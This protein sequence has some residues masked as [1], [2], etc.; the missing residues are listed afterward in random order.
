MNESNKTTCVDFDEIV[1][2]IHE[3][4]DYDDQTIIDILELETDYLNS[5]GIIS[6]DELID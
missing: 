6:Y 2:Y 4:S 3:N 5:I 1:K